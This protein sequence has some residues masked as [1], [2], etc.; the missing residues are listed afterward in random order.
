MN[1]FAAPAAFSALALAVPILLNYM[2]RARR[3]RQV[4]PST[5]LWRQATRNVAAARPWQRLRP[6]VL[7]FLQLLALA[8]LVVALAAP[9]RSVTGVGGH[10]LVLVIDASGSMLAMDEAVSRVDAARADAERLIDTLA[11]GVVVSVIAAET[12]PR[13]LVSATPDR[14]Q[15]LRVLDSV[16]ATEGPANFAE[17]FLL[18]ESLETPSRPATIAIL[19][20]GGLTREEARLVPPGAVIRSVGRSGKNVSV[21]R[22]D[23]AEGAGGFTAVAEVHNFGPDTASVELTLELNGT[24]LSTVALRIP[25]SSS[26]ERSFELGDEPGRLGGRIASDDPL[27]ADDRAFAVLE[28]TRPRR[29]LLETPGNLF[30]ESLLRQLPGAK[31]T[32]S[33]QAEDPSGYDLAVYDRVAVPDKV[34]VPA[35]FVTP[36]RTSASVHTSGVLEAP[37]ISYLAAD[38]PLLGQVDLSDL[39]VARAQ[40]VE[41]P[42]SRTLVAGGS[43]T[44]ETPLI[45]VW[46][47]G[48][49]RRAWIGF[50]LQESNLPLQVAFPILGDHLISWL[51]G[52]GQVAA[53]FA[54]DPITAAA[55]PT[56]DKVQIRIPGGRSTTIHPGERFDETDRAG[57][58][59]LTY[60]AGDKVVAEQT[61]ALSFPPRES[62]LL[63]RGIQA[64]AG[65]RPGLVTSARQSIATWVLAAAL[66]LLVLEW[67]WAHGRPG[68]RPPA[69]PEAGL[70]PPLRRRLR[71]RAA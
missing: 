13:V 2:L 43:G 29:I 7:L 15:A 37:A 64:P 58:Y 14:S 23:V 47:E 61:L 21:S 34:P 53:R 42:G 56:A 17:A 50:D 9:F 33:D 44:E 48:T 54:G 46:A 32:V 45:A 38:D 18:A 12:R 68:R 6:S 39:A 8:T 67:W 1:G 71:R 30:L 19:S 26:V 24:P 63:P 36:S 20:D 55:V 40:R 28:R 65:G 70:S 59:G 10:H 22:L 60:L 41:I 16:D 35:L 5:F 62:D 27:A 66:A 11:P 25:P 69:R 3:P 51:S 31:V 49:L 52:S 4:V 57:F